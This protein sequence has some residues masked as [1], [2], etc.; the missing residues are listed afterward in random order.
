[1]GEYSSDKIL[2]A[3]NQLDKRLTD[4]IANYPLCKDN[5][6][7]VQK[8]VTN[9]IS[10]HSNVLSTI[11]IAIGKT[12]QKTDF[13]MSKDLQSDYLVT[14]QNFLPTSFQTLDVINQII[15]KYKLTLFKINESSYEAIQRFLNTFADSATIDALKLEFS[16]RD[17]SLK[18]F[19][20]KLKRMKDK[21]LRTQLFVGIPL[22]LL[23]LLIIFTGEHFLGKA[24]NG[25]QLILLK[26][27]IALSVSIVGSSL[28]EGS[29]QTDW[30]LQKGLTI[31]AVGWVAV[32]LLMY[33]LNPANPGDVY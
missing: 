20:K 19:N 13:F 29:V 31:R 4:F 23:S 2:Q 17:I 26:A 3:K 16:N 28:I 25:I 18:G 1:M 33:F 24:F 21:Y 32:F 15:K 27:L 5:T 10:E 8:L 30:T 9:M 11:N 12:H 7:E 6:N 14:L 22:L